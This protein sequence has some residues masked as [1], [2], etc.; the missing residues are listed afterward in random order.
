MPTLTGERLTL[1]LTDTTHP[2]PSLGELGM[3]DEQ[4]QLLLKH[5]S[6]RAG[7]I[8]FA[9]PG[10]VGKSTTMIASLWEINSPDN[11]I[12]TLEDTVEFEIPGASQTQVRSRQGLTYTAALASAL[13]QDFDVIAIDQL[14]EEQIIDLAVRGA[15]S[16][17]LIL[18]AAS[19]ATVVQALAQLSATNAHPYLLASA[20]RLVI[21]QQLLPQLCQSC[22][23]AVPIPR[24]VQREIAAELK[25]VP[26]AYLAAQKLPAQHSFFESAG[27]AECQE[28]KQQGQVALFEV[29]PIFTALR[30]ALTSRADS[31][32]LEQLIRAKGYP[33]LRQDG[34]IK[35]LQ[36]RVRYVD[37]V[38]ATA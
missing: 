9:G 12:A 6:A 21:A 20:L 7:L 16:G 26:K 11:A 22:K 23:E 10:R 27:C 5:L 15:E 18:A 35:A 36:G 34:I 19:A 14:G 33:S 28:T 32:T 4:Q 3:T 13:R 31:A 17:K 29:V 2:P 24:E 38:H 25:K 8:V 1:Q 30:H 37:V